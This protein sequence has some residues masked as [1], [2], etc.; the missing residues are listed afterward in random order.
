[1]SGSSKITCIRKSII[2][3]KSADKPKPNFVHVSRPVSLS[4]Q[5]IVIIVC[6]WGR[7]HNRFRLFSV[8]NRFKSNKVM[9]LTSQ[10]EC[11]VVPVTV[12]VLTN[13]SLAPPF[14]KS[15]EK[16]W[17]VREAVGNRGSTCRVDQKKRRRGICLVWCGGLRFPSSL[18]QCD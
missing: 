3:I 8:Q 15:K 5:F 18:T 12:Y 16:F 6:E 11:I 13:K 4:R 9:Y 1:M 7:L 14:L 10:L 2:E 17:T